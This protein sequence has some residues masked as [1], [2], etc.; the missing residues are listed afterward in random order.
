MLETGFQ[1]Y[2]Y[3]PCLSIPLRGEKDGYEKQGYSRGDYRPCCVAG[4]NCGSRCRSRRRRHQLTLCI[5]LSEPVPSGIE[6]NPQ[7]RDQRDYKLA[8]RPSDMRS[9]DNSSINKPDYGILQFASGTSNVTV[10]KGT[11]ITFT[12]SA[13]SCQPANG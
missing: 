4:W 11:P 3:A 9:P 2:R 5:C 13:G 12:V 1:Q 6:Q 10:A 8:Q 7:L